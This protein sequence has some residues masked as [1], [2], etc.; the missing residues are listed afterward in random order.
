M[1]FTCKNI[2]DTEKIAKN[3]AKELGKKAGAIILLYG[4]MG[5]GKTTFTRLLLKSLDKSINAQSPTFSIINQ[6]KD[7]IY[8]IDL[9]RLEDANESAFANIG[10]QEIIDE[11]NFVFIEWSE[12]LPPILLESTKSEIYKVNVSAIDESTRKIEIRRTK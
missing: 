2:K 5:T 11:E 12:N 8:H 6:Y 10:L 1:E 3:L 7:N 9:Y 4:G